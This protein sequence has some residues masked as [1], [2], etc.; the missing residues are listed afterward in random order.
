MSETREFLL[1]TE[2]LLFQV[3][4]IRAELEQLRRDLGHSQGYPPSAEPEPEWSAADVRS[5]TTALLDAPTETTPVSLN[6][7][8]RRTSARLPAAQMLITVCH[9]GGTADPQPGWVVDYSPSGLGILVDEE[10]PA[11]N[12]LHI[13]PFQAADDVPWVDVT[14]RHS[15]HDQRGWRLGCQFRAEVTWDDLRLF[16]LE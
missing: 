3:D 15:R 8:E 11:G 5:A 7:H 16:G 9:P 4:A 6:G 13:R 1:R 14:V 2:H 10:I 12:M